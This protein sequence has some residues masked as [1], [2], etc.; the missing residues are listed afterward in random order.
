MTRRI[1][2]L[3]VSIAAL[4][5]AV[6]AYIAQGAGA[7]EPV[8]VADF[9][10]PQAAIAQAS[11]GGEFDANTGDGALFHPAASAGQSACASGAGIGTISVNEEVSILCKDGEVLGFLV[12]EPGEDPRLVK[13][14]QEADTCPSTGQDETDD[15]SA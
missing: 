5:L 6:A 4:G 1:G 12:V 11:G 15:P 7:V 2:V 10:A 8:A 14:L 9:G 3:S 13:T